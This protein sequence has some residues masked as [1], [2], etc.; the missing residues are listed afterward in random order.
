MIK[1]VVVARGVVILCEYSEDSYDYGAL[2]SPLLEFMVLHPAECKARILTHSTNLAIH[3]LPRDA[4]VF[5]V[6]GESSD[7]NAS[8]QEL[9]SEVAGNFIEQYG[10][11]SEMATITL[12]YQMHDFCRTITNLI[13][14][15]S[16]G[17]EKVATGSDSLE[18]N[19]LT[20]GSLEALLQQKGFPVSN[21]D[22][23][24][25]LPLGNAA[26]QFQ[27]RAVIRRRAQWW[28]NFIMILAL[29]ITLALLV[30]ILLS[31]FTNTHE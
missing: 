25:S 24:L 17:K 23:G 12:P 5:M 7:C 11:G 21:G 1:H 18:P 10:P 14:Q 22:Q 28:K 16:N 4:L 20:M 27:R 8:A 6:I 31:V 9:L 19:I 29:A 15:C 13:T 30:F 3:L 2:V 26:L